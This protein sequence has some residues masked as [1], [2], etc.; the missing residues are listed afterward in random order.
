M[1]FVGSQCFFQ[2]ELIFHDQFPVGQLVRTNPAFRRNGVGISCGNIH[3]QCFL[4]IIEIHLCGFEILAEFLFN[5]IDGW[6]VMIVA[7]HGPY[8]ITLFPESLTGIGSHTR[9]DEYRHFI[10]PQRECSGIVMIMT[11]G[12]VTSFCRQEEMLFVAQVIK[13]RFGIS[14]CFGNGMKRLNLF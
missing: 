5:A 1:N 7:A 2:V 11:F 12:I 9:I 10:Y 14:Y 8:G 4:F 13:L 3:R 6:Q